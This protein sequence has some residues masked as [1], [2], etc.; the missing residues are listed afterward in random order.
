VWQV[1]YDELK[2][3]GLEI[4][5]VAL[6]TAGRPAVEAKVRPTDLDERPDVVRRLR[7]WTEAQWERKAAPQYPCLI[8]AEHVVAELYGMTNVPMGVWIDEEGRIVRPAEPAGVTDHFRRMDPDTFGIPD[9]DAE[10]LQANRER[11]VDAL[12]DWV[13]NGAASPYALSPE[14]VRRRMR[15]PGP[16]DALAAVHVRL[17]RHLFERG[18]V[19]AAQEHLDAAVELCPEKWTLRRQAMVL[20]PDLV[21]AINV[22]EGY[23]EALEELGPREFYPAIDM[24]GIDNRPGWLERPGT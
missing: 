2:E 24:P 4:I 13:R 8:D 6:D 3:Q 10:T 18:E 20:D 23:Y 19:E 14:D 15:R 5:A 16:Q 7:G 12:R 1:I 9:E 22:S 17:G 21:G 11:Y